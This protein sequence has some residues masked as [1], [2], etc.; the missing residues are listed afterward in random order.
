MFY[1]IAVLP[2]FSVNI[3]VGDVEIILPTTKEIEVTVRSRYYLVSIFSVITH[4]KKKLPK[5]MY[6]LFIE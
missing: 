4:G 6:V 5:I 3:D 1:V 2:R